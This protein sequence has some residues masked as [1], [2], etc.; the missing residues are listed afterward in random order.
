MTVQPQ[1]CA[2]QRA[3]VYAL[4]DVE[5]FD[6]FTESQLSALNSD[7]WSIDWLV[8]DDDVATLIIL[9]QPG[10]ASFRAEFESAV[11]RNGFPQAADICK[12][13]SDQ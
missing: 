11:K 12:R 9:A 7:E 8:K 4:S 2:M 1:P 13:C 3:F 6:D 5:N 10:N